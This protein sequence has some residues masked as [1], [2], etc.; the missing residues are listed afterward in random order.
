MRFWLA[1]RGCGVSWGELTWIG[2]ARGIDG[3][4]V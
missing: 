3:V 1:R 4:W 2:M